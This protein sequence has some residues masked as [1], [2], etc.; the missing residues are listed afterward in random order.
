MN[1]VQIAKVK[2]ILHNARSMTETDLET[3][4][5][6]ISSS[7]GNI[8]VKELF[9]EGIDSIMNKLL[10]TNIALVPDADVRLGEI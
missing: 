5:N 1:S 7:D 9:L 6:N 4:R 2:T 10:L 8:K 3:L